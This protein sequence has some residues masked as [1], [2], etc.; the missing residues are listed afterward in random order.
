MT[1]PRKHRPNPEAA[2]SRTCAVPHL[3]QHA[4]STPFSPSPSIVLPLSPSLAAN[5]QTFRP[6]RAWFAQKAHSA[7]PAQRLVATHG[8]LTTSG[9][10]KEKQSKTV[11]AASSPCPSILPPLRMSHLRLRHGAA[12]ELPLTSEN[13][14]CLSV[15]TWPPG[16][17]AWPGLGRQR[18]GDRRMGTL[19]VSFG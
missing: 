14:E 7:C 13:G 12:A 19:G 3:Q 10:R 6:K 1:S 5:Q 4:S 11:S 15:R 9:N 17:L 16:H 2:H 18:Q 8:A